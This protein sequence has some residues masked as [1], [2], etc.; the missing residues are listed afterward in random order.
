MTAKALGNQDFLNEL[1]GNKLNVFMRMYNWI[2]NVLFDSNNTGKTFSERRTQNKYLQE[3]KSKF[4]IAYNTAYKGS[5][6]EQYSLK[7]RDKNGYP[8]YESDLIQ[9]ITNKEKVKYLEKQ[10]E[11]LKG[12]ALF[13]NINGKKIKAYFDDY[14]VQK[15]TYGTAKG[16]KAE[17]RKGFQ[18]K[19][20]LA[21]DL[22][23]IINN[24]KFIGEADEIS[25]ITNTLPKNKAHQ[26]VRKWYTF[27]NK[28]NYSGEIY[29]VLT[30][31]RKKDDG[32]YGYSIKFYERKK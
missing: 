31:V 19:E 17:T 25:N 32:N 15:T 14:G 10:M 16:D 20:M 22:Y 29:T 8:I 28:I 6:N 7:G 13:F 3:L 11:V 2:K 9:E 5:T 27:E 18:T 12:K 4:E 24:S 30:T 21:T 23:T 26:D 1:A